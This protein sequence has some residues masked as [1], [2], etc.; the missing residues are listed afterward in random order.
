MP[1]L[2]VCVVNICGS[3]D[4]T[5]CGLTTYLHTPLKDLKHD[6]R[7]WS[8]SSAVTLRCRNQRR[9]GSEAGIG[10]FE[11]RTQA[12]RAG[13]AEGAAAGGGLY[14]A[15]DWQRECQESETTG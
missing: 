8:C 5:V 6:N 2:H 15:R 9:R 11:E 13:I 14:N 12:A 7:L 4:I 3:V 10:D 1:C